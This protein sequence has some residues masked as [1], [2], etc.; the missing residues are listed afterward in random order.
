[1]SIRHKTIKQI[2]STM[3]LLVV[4]F[5]FFLQSPVK[6]QV[7]PLY[8]FKGKIVASSGLPVADGRYDVSFAL[9]TQ[10]AGGASIW[11]ESLTAATRFSATVSGS[12]VGASTITYNYNADANEST[13][14]VGQHLSSGSSTALVVDFDTA[15]NT[16][17]VAGTA[18]V[19]VNGAAL[20]NRPRLTGGVLDVDLGTVAGLAGINFNQ[21]LYLEVTFNAETFQPRKLLATVP[22]A[23]NAARLNGLDA[24][25]FLNSSQNATIT[26]A[27]TFANPLNISTSS[28]ATALTVTQGGA[29]NVLELKNSTSSVMTVLASGFVGIG[30]SS[31]SSQLTVYGNALIEGAGR[32]LSFGG[33]SG[34]LGY[35]F[36]DNGGVIELRNAGGSWQ[37]IGAGGSGAVAPGTAGQVAFYNVSGTTVVGSS[38]LFI[39][40]SGNVAVGTTTIAAGGERNPK[41]QVAGAVAANYY[42]DANGN[43]C[44][45][46]SNGWGMS[47]SFVGT[48]TAT[49]NG[50]F[51]SSTLRGYQ[52][53]NNI[54][55]AQFS[56]SH[57]CRT[58]EI[59]YTIATKSIANF[60]GTAWIA[61]GPP[62][63]TS[64][65]ND[66]NG[67][68]SSSS[69][70][71][72]AFWLFDSNGGGA[73]WLTNC[74]GLKPIACCR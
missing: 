6:A 49:T 26:A 27:W 11:S 15:A 66:C 8:N 45:D 21:L 34:A 59:I 22:T 12:A 38:A 58:D 3:V 48:T 40:G 67:W 70:S 42:C 23:F 55:T 72:G 50:Q 2:L 57:F 61:E 54:C 32:Y 20:D 43:N 41:L 33:S 35:G 73:G 74:S 19:W 16:V 7:N 52:A 60:S 5:T 63:Y 68:T 65:S 46:A 44:V 28:A 71:L 51:A 53:G 9:F 56:G 39:D 13:L 30:T 62:G 31:P 14:R 17:T 1:M 18:P 4:L 24:S 47:G 25:S 10:A 69:V 29:G 37:P 36:R 64:N